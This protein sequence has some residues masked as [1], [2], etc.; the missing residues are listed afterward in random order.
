MTG[1][2]RFLVALGVAMV[3]IVAMASAAAAGIQGSGLVN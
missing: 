3:T 1:W 2:R